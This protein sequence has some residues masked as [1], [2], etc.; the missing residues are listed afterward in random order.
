MGLAAAVVIAV[1]GFFGFEFYTQHRITSEV[2]AAFAQIRAGGGKASHGKVSFDLK[3]RTLQIDDIASESATQPPVRLKIASLTASGVGQPDTGRF[4]ADSIET[5]DIEISANLAG[6]A[7]GSLSYKMPRAVMKDYSG[8]TALR[9][10][11]TPASV[12][13]MYRSALEQ[14]AAVQAASVSV[15]SMT[16]TVNFGAALS[17]AFAYSGISL[18]DI[19][20]GKIA[21]TQVERANFTL[22]TQQAGKADKMTGEIANLSCRDI[23]ANAAA[24]I[25]D[26]QKANDDRYYSFY[27]KT[28]AGPYTITSA[29]GVRTR[30]DQMTIDGVGARP[31]RLQL[32]AL[33]AMLQAAG[34]TSPTPAQTRE[35][36]DK[37]AALYEGMRIGTAEMR[38]LSTET[39]QGLVKL[40]AIR[41][42]LEGGKIGEFA[43]EGL[44]TN[45]PKGA[46][47]SRTFHTQIAGY[48]PLHADIGAVRQPGTAAH[49]RTDRG[50]VST[51]RGCR[52]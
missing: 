14:F 32:P 22:N 18:Q 48:R 23:D 2:E 39:P 6:P 51:H 4:L 3:S 35:L 24:A 42:N 30:I 34:T 20:G 40:Q 28:S 45:T 9:Q 49:S 47:Q 16:G 10:A 38:G 15:P 25:L 29:L 1:G 26:P 43:V 31:S 50:A 37:I 41:F 12:I 19:K 5:S 13:E 11:S 52:D 17:G 46:P 7:G 36:I 44:D 8:P 27:G 21:T 33:L